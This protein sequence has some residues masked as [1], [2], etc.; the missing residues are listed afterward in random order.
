MERRSSIGF[1][2]EVDGIG[3]IRPPGEASAITIVQPYLF[4]FLDVSIVGAIEAR[5]V[6]VELLDDWLQ[7]QQFL[8]NHINHQNKTHSSSFDV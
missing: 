2:S 4:P 3:E 6:R 7:L 1:L 8:Q 5:P